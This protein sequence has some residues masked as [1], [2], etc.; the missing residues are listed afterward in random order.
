LIAALAEG[1]THLENALFSD[2]SKYFVQALTT[3]GFEVI[4]NE[5]A[6]SMTLTGLGG[7]IP[8]AQAALYIGNAGTAARFLTAMLT[9]G[10]GEYQ[11]DGVER[12]RQRPIGDLVAALRQLG[13]NPEGTLVDQESLCPPVTIHA[14][15]LPGGKT[16]VRGDISS[17]FLSGL[18]MVA[19]YAQKQVEITVEGPLHSKPYIDLTLGV[20][21]DFGIEVQREGYVNFHVKPDKYRSPGTYHIE[22]DA[23]AASYFFSVPA[24]C[25]GWVAVANLSR[26]ARQGDITFVDILS[27]MGCSVNEYPDAIRISGPDRLM[28]IDA[29]MSNISDT[30][31]TL[32]AIAPFAETPTTIRGIASSRLKET[33]RIAATVTELHRL[34]VQVDEFPDGMTIYPCKAIQPAHIHT[35]DDHRMAMAFSLVGLRVPGIE[36][37]NP[38]CVAKTFPDYFDVLEKLR[39]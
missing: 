32:A 18:L 19:P 37:Q 30:S 29:D 28:G 8:A 16:T 23:S 3:L 17:Q 13:A 10:H 4:L 15:G 20:M 5:D 6:R 24:I 14:S 11:I 22:S 27:K 26:T 9:T 33:D 35:Y 7:K 34:G 25:G 36:I 21:A 1:T 2:D 31:I 38:G 12:M 39:R